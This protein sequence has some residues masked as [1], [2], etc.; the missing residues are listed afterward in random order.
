MSK[1]ILF[2]SS[3]RA[4]SNVVIVGAKRTAVGSHLGQLSNLSAPHLGSIAVKGALSTSNVDSK[5]VE[6][7]YFG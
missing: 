5:E 7:V 3:R 1:N 6:E 2:A 4:F